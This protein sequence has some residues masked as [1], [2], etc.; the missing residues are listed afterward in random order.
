MVFKIL[1]KS[2]QE[3]CLRKLNGQNT[4]LKCKKYFIQ[5]IV[6]SLIPVKEGF[7]LLFFDCLFRSPVTTSSPIVPTTRRLTS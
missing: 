1:Y 6:I 5:T 2:K 7:S 4:G 3:L